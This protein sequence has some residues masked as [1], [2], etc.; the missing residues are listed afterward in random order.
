M[1]RNINF[2]DIYPE[3]SYIKIFEIY[4]ISKMP[5]QYISD[6]ESLKNFMVADKQLI[7][8]NN[9]K[10]PNNRFKCLVEINSSSPN[11]LKE[12]K[13]ITNGEERCFTDYELFSE[14]LTG[15]C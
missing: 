6:E 7:V 10:N 12:L 15:V 11:G 14:F 13:K 9:Y 4:D 8:I 2:Y 5:F 3:I 1:I